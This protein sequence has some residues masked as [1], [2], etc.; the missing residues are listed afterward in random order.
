M[1]AMLFWRGTWLLRQECRRRNARNWRDNVHLPQMS[2][3][4]TA[5]AAEST[6]GEGAQRGGGLHGALGTLTGV[7]GV[8]V[9]G[10]SHGALGSGLLGSLGHQGYGPDDI[11]TCVRMKKDSSH[12]DRHHHRHHRR[13]C[14]GRRHRRRRRRELRSAKGFVSR[15]S[16]RTLLGVRGLTSLWSDSV[17]VAH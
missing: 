4:G 2:G 17:V 5:S 16:H 8:R 15:T 1:Q 6:G 13:R 14:R 11:S 12:Q 10:S 7:T 3:G 9:T